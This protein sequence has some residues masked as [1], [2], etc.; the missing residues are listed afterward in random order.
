[1]PNG[2]EIGHKFDYNWYKIGNHVESQP[3]YN[4]RQLYTRFK[5]DSNKI[6]ARTWKYEF[7]TVW[8]KSKMRRAFAEEVNTLY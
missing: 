6:G 2:L 7:N 5:F 4:Q 1:M 8:N 3:A